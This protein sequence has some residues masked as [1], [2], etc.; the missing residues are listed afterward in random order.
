MRCQFFLFLFPLAVF[1]QLVDRPN[2]VL[3]MADDMGMGDSSAY[4]FFKEGNT[5]RKQLLGYD[6]G[7]EAAAFQSLRENYPALAAHSLPKPDLEGSVTPIFIVGM[8]RSGTTL[9]EQ[10][11]SVLTDLAVLYLAKLT[12]LKTDKEMSLREFLNGQMMDL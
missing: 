7:K 10:I 6:K 8:P 1:S 12:S 11:I 3:F 5:L 4:Q 9:V 2:V